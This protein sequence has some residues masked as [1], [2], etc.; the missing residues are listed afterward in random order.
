MPDEGANAVRVYLTQRSGKTFELQTDQLLR[1]N[2]AVYALQLRLFDPLGIEV[3]PSR[4]A[5]R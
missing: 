3:S 1:V 2:K 5:I 4:M